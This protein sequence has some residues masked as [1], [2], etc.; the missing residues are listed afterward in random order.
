[1]P[2]METQRVLPFLFISWMQDDHGHRHHVRLG[3]TAMMASNRA[4][5]ALLAADAT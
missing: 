4:L 3:F 2:R 5:N 1:M